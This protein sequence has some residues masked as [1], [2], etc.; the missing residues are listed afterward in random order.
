LAAE[1]GH[2]SSVTDPEAF[3]AQILS[4]LEKAG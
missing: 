1:G 3:N 2:G 4:F